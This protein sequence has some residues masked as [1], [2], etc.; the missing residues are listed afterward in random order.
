MS[1]AEALLDDGRSERAALDHPVWR[2]IAVWF[3]PEEFRFPEAMDAGFLRRLADAR[4][5]ARVP[6][7]IVSDHRPPEHNARVGGVPRSAHLEV[8][9]RAVDL[10]V[11]NNEERFRIVAALLAERFERIGIYPARPDGSGSVHVD[12]SQIH[13]APRLWTRR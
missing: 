9:C 13:P 4:Q 12:A 3:A 1:P 6:F 8:P 7:R 10:Q 11:A 2:E 5:R